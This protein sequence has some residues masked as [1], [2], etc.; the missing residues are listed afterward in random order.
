MALFPGIIFIFTLIPYI[1]IAGFQEQIF[2]A[3]RE[4]LPTTSYEAAKYTIDDILNNKRGNLLS[5]TFI[6]VLVLAT[7][8]TLSLL[9]AFTHSYH[10]ID[11]KNFWQQYLSA[12]WLTVVL[13]VL[14]LFSIVLVSLGERFL[15][16]LAYKDVLEYYLLNYI[17]IGRAIV[18]VFTI[19]LSISLLYSYGSVRG[20]HWK[21]FSPGSI[22]ATVLVILSSLAFG[23]YVDNISQYNKLYGS[24]GTLL[25]IM[26][27]IYINAI[28]LIIGFELNASIAGAK[29]HQASLK[30]EE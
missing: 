13:A 16:F 22:L 25:V 28:G 10:K 3:L 11:F 1:P 8:G 17:M 21:F 14:T 23:Y 30:K 19:Q 2:Q 24:I 5:I 4:V 26:L 7:N 6:M 18:L 9:S 29:S 12:L 15:S 27:W 20:K